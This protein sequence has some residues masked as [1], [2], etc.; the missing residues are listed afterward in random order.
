MPQ[1]TAAKRKVAKISRIQLSR[2]LRRDNPPSPRSFASPELAE[3]PTPASEAPP[4]PIFHSES[5]EAA[6]DQAAHDPDAE[7]ERE[8]SEEQAD[9]SR[10]AAS[11]LPRVQLELTPGSLSDWSDLFNADKFN[12]IDGTT[13]SLGLI[14]GESSATV[15]TSARTTTADGINSSTA[16][17]DVLESGIGEQGRS[18]VGGHHQPASN[19]SFTSNG[20]DEQDD[21]L[22]VRTYHCWLHIC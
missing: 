15:D 5:I 3:L 6:H 10:E 8:S 13:N 20:S 9:R 22:L 18:M 19:P 17:M 7:P 4:V 2:T 1:Y 11:S 21:T 16:T 14:R 12:F